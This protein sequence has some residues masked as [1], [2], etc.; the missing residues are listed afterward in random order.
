MPE[1]E[2]RRTSIYD[3]A[4]AREFL[5]TT[6][7]LKDPSLEHLGPRSGLDGVPIVWKPDAGPQTLF[8]QSTAREAMIG[9]SVG[10][11]KTDAL[12][13]GALRF[14]YNP[15]YRAIILRR[16]KEDLRE[17]I[18]RGREMYYATCPGVEW[19][20]KRMRFEFPTGASILMGSAQYEKDIE[21]YKTFQFSYIG[22]DELT[23]FTKKQYVYMLSRNRA[24]AGSHLPLMVRSGTNPEGVGHAWVFKRFVEGKDPFRI[25][26][27]RY[28][29]EKPDGSTFE[30]EL[31]RQF[32]PS[33]IFDNT[34][35]ADVGDYIAGLRSMGKDLAEALLYGK[36]DYFRGQMFPYTLKESQRGL[37]QRTHYVIRCMDY[38]W[39][40]P[41]VIYWLVVYPK[42]GGSELEV[43]E[44]LK[45]T[46][47]NVDG[48]AHMIKHREEQLRRDWD[49]D[50]PRLS[51]IDPS[52]AKSEGTSSGQNIMMMLMNQGVWFTKANNDRQSG[53]AQ[54]RRLLESGRLTFWEGKAPYLMATLP[55]LVRD[56]QKADDIRGKQD[57]HGADALRYG[58]MAFVD[59]DVP[60]PEDKQPPKPGMDQVFPRIVEGLQKGEHADAG[61]AVGW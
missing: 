20:E 10:G 61:I 53:W 31:T 16:E 18:D 46:E 36:W 39:T 32:I 29:I 27:Y 21:Q 60:L 37:K 42:P 56:E 47:T 48:L 25:Y 55:K 23:T 54:L 3:R 44:E 24:K 26:R 8:L 15:A 19:V 7:G 49:L 9:G 5:P 45:L 41:S 51:V 33:S 12:I 35:I 6:L 22:F 30:T 59:N 1:Q 14:V 58:A 17:T 52:A 4:T 28:E 2:Q 11:G 57:D 43:V 13:M 34:H 38:G 40:E 50:A